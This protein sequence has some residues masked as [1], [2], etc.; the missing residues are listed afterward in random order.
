MQRVKFSFIVLSILLMGCSTS[1][2]TTD[3]GD[4]KPTYRIQIGSNKG[5]IVDNT[6]LSEIPNTTVDAYSGATSSG[7]NAGVK[8]IFPLKRNAIESGIDYIF[9]AQTFTY[10]DINN[11]FYGK[12]ELAVSQ[13]MV[14]ITY[15][16]AFFRRSN[17]QGLFQ[18]KVG[19][20]AQFNLVNIS[21]GIG[22]LPSYSTKAISQ[23]ATLGFSTTPISL[24]SGAKLGFYI[25][26]Y[27]G[28]QA[29]F[30][31][32]NRTEFEMP[33]TAFL[34]YGFIYQF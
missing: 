26:G 21:D 32:Y 20:A 11:G 25:D 23:G 2:L 18:I 28:S 3:K 33:G 9:N 10:S 1:T 19:Y 8:V 5:G 6:K 27:R 24:R 7:F 4:W 29:Y 31:F 16:I 15:S 22:N 30:D 14:P 17:P 34:K 13:F 12:R